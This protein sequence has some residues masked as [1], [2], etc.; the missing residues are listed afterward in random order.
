M[1]T[2]DTQHADTSPVIEEIFASIENH[3]S[4]YFLIEASAGT[5]KTWTMEK[6]ILKLVLRGYE[7]DSILAVT[8]TE[9]AAFELSGRIRKS[10]EEYQDQCY[11]PVIARALK[12][13]NS[14][15]IF[16]IHGFARKVL[17]EFGSIHPFSSD[18]SIVDGQQFFMD[19]LEIFLRR[20]DIS[21]NEYIRAF[22]SEN[23]IDDLKKL[24]MDA[25]K[26]GSEFYEESCLTTE[27]I[28][29]KIISCLFPLLI[30]LVE[31]TA[32]WQNLSTFDDLILNLKKA[33]EYE[34]GEP[35]IL[36]SLRKRYAVGIIDEF[37]D[38]DAA[39]WEIFRKIFMHESKTSLLFLVGDPKQSIYSFRGA[40]LNVYFNAKNEIRENPYGKILTLDTN[41]RSSPG[42]IDVAEKFFREGFFSSPNQFTAGIK[43]GKNT[44]W[45]ESPAFSSL[46]VL[47][48]SSTCPKEEVASSMAG[49]IST[50]LKTDG[51]FKA[52]LNENGEVQHTRI[53]ASDIFVLTRTL[54]HAKLMEEKIRELG[55]PCF[56][57]KKNDLYSRES[58]K[59]ILEI[60]RAVRTLDPDLVRKSFLT[61]VFG[62]SLKDISEPSGRVDEAWNVIRKWNSYARQHKFAHLF[63]EILSDS[64]LAENLF[65]RK[66]FDKYHDF[67]TI[68]E[69]LFNRALGSKS[70]IEGIVKNL[71]NF[72]NGRFNDDV[73]GNID[74]SKNPDDSEAVQILTGHK[75]KG[76]ENE[77]VFYFQTSRHGSFRNRIATTFSEGRMLWWSGKITDKKKE[78]EINNILKFEEE[79]ENQRLFYVV[80]TR[81]AKALFLPFF[82]LSGKKPSGAAHLKAQG[83]RI[84]QLK[85]MPSANIRFFEYP[86]E[87]PSEII[88]NKQSENTEK[89]IPEFPEDRKPPDLTRR[90]I[91]VESYSSIKH[92][93][94]SGVKTLNYSSSYEKDD[95]GAEFGTM[96]HEIMELVDLDSFRHS[97]TYDEWMIL[98]TTTDLMLKIRNMYEISEMSVETGFR[99]CYSGYTVEIGITDSRK[100]RLF[101]PPV[102]KREME[103]LEKITP[104]KLS[105]LNPEI[106]SS[107][108]PDGFIR[109]IIDYAALIDDE[110]WIIDWKTDFLE[111]YESKA[112]DLHVMENYSI[113]MQLYSQAGEKIAALHENTRY[114]GLIYVFLRGLISGQDGFWV[115]KSYD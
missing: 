101:Q 1:K 12:K 60:L 43:C 53:T 112:I 67:E 40:D 79:L 88:D 91:T 92:K 114:G 44:Q 15:G 47:E 87:Y 55:I 102:I 113:Q 5:G 74:I 100:I 7:I 28:E 11:T 31:Q 76:L 41:Y 105:G 25:F 81:A 98:G 35:S 52:V 49:M 19:T 86:F 34:R 18:S 54:N 50:L 68:F 95:R 109:G 72:M 65:V 57:F 89:N 46:N 51:H 13:F 96:V 115:M 38:T 63:E 82:V 33:L 106:A 24:F 111:T 103:F 83:A 23:S 30:N 85:K 29:S 78:K 70:G 22:L 69:E 39:Q 61:D 17:Q 6:I 107:L 62:L 36:M 110:I 2:Y 99:M 80:F 4:G 32:T 3:R 93:L 97:Y 21:E 66:E 56:I 77:I 104:S 58:A 42:M 75:S 84:D 37:Q 14:A 59:Q 20:K 64:K 73:S 9:K 94:S 45:F 71:E 10:L 48:F 26:T 90:G 108:D 27:N 16:T 8:F